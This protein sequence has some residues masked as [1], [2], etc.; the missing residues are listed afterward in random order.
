MTEQEAVAF[1][2]YSGRGLSLMLRSL[3]TAADM[4][5]DALTPGS[6]PVLKLESTRQRARRKM[7]RSRRR[8]RR[9]RRRLT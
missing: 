9:L 3:A 6:G 8:L 2:R 1:A 4:M 7:R 5:V